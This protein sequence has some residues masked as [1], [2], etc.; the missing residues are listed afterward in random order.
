MTRQWSTAYL[1]VTYAKRCTKMTNETMALLMH[2]IIQSMIRNKTNDEQML[3][4]TTAIDE[5]KKL[6]EEK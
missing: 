1:A 6:E 5:L 3:L 4:L 2:L